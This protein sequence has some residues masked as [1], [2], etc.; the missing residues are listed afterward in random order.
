MCKFII[1]VVCN[2]LKFPIK[3]FGI[4]FAS[5]LVANEKLYQN[6]RLWNILFLIFFSILTSLSLILHPTP[7]SI[8]VLLFWSHLFQIWHIRWHYVFHLFKPWKT[9]IRLS[10]CRIRFGRKAWKIKRW[11]FRRIGRILRVS[12]IDSSIKTR[13]S[14]SWRGYFRFLLPEQVLLRWLFQSQLLTSLVSGGH[15]IFSD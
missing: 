11:H 2:L 13:R 9:P 6:G 10:R 1:V 8:C 3:F 12:D 4:S 15:F 14:I 5:F 7:R